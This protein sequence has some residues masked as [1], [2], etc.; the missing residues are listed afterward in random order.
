MNTQIKKNK[1]LE[2][3]K[4]CINVIFYSLVVLLLLFSIANINAKDDYE[5]PNVFG[6]GFT[7]VSSNSMEG[8]EKDSF[9]TSDVLW[10]S[11]VNND[12]KISKIKIGDIITFK[13]FSTQIN[14]TILNSH[15]VVDIVYNE[16]GSLDYFITQG[17]RVA[18][19][20]DYKYE[21]GS[22]DNHV[23]KIEFVNPEDV[24]AVYVGK[25]TNAGSFFRFIQSSAGFLLCIVIPVA[26]FFVFELVLI[27]LQFSKM[28]QK[29]NEEKH[30]AEMER[31]KA[32]QAEEMAK[33]KERL[34]AEMLA[35]LK[36]EQNIKD[37]EE[38]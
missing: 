29:K 22:D 33:E 35:E 18:M 25:W 4:I 36:K 7:T 34:R 20:P 21:I 27:I 1:T 15:R 32:I 11:V 28:K 26:V 31:L 9:T 24:R 23:D 3:I 14:E 8:N 5:V 6:T 16:D 30:N 17:D 37:G 10:L 2:I 19:N 38:I 13:Y 12:K